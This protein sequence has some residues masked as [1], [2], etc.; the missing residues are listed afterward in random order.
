[1]G[2]SIPTFYRGVAAGTLPLPCYVVPGAPRWRRSALHVAAE[3]TAKRPAEAVA[4]R[5]A[6]RNAKGRVA[7]V[8]AELINADT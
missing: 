3:A 7:S 6:A 4:K 2:I 5:V 1:L 8:A